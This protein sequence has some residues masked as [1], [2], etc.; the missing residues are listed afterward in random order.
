[1]GCIHIQNQNKYFVDENTMMIKVGC[2]GFPI[3]MKTYFNKFETVEIQKTFYTLPTI[4]NAEKWRSMAPKNFEFTIKA[5]QGITHP[6]SSPTYKRYK[7]KLKKPQNYGFF[8]QT[9]EVINAWKETEKICSILK[10]K[11]VLFQCPASFKPN[12]ENIEN[13]LH[14]F[15]KIRNNSY[16]YV[17][18]PR[19][20]EWTD[21]IIL[22]ICKK[23]GLTHCVDP[24]SHQPVTKELAYFRLHGSPPGKKMYNYDYTKKDLKELIKLCR[25]FNIVYCFFNN[26]NMYKNALQLIEFI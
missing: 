11:H 26:I 5:W 17:W 4:E 20:K 2:C 9:D 22:E 6:A 21:D 24:F 23:T 25:S 3:S 10:A 18:E 13:I 16:H 8:Q 7:G 19:G 15:K 12:D 1:M 14:F